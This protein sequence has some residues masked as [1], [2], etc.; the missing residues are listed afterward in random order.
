MH[1][2]TSEKFSEYNTTPIIIGKKNNNISVSI[3]GLFY[4]IYER[5][6]ENL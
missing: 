5:H 4:D 3:G 2:N 6:L 1:T